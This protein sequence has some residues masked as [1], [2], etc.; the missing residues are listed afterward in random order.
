LQTVHAA[1]AERRVRG[2]HDP[3]GRSSFM[4]LLGNVS[5]IYAHGAGQRAG[6]LVVSQRR[7]ECAVGQVLNP[8][9]SAT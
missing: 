5:T 3:S 1:S 6:E 2:L 4:F 9:V 8:H 7:T